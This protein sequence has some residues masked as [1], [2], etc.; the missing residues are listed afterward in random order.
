MN[1]TTARPRLALL[2]A[3]LLAGAISVALVSHGLYW[4]W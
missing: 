2:L 1:D 3:V 4:W